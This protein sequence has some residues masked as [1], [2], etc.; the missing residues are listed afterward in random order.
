MTKYENIVLSLFLLCMAQ[1]IQ[2]TH[3]IM[4]CRSASHCRNTAAFSAHDVE[5]NSQNMLNE[6]ADSERY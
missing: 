3:I 4:I 5:P 6:L 1:Q 2:K